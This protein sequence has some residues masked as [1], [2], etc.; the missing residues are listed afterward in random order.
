MSDERPRDRLRADTAERILRAA[1]ERLREHPQAP[2]SHEIVAEQAGVSA[3]TVY[4]HFPTQADLVRGVWQQLR[5]R[6]GTT[7]PRTLEAIV[8][9]LRALFA[10]FERNGALTRAMLAAAPRA[11]YARAGS[12]EG[13]AAF[14][15]A[16]APLLAGRPP[17]AQRQLVAQCL[18]IYSAPF[19][20]LLRERGPLCAGAAAD[21]A[22]AAMQAVLDAA[23]AS[24]PS[25]TPPPR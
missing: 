5:D 10:Q 21:A 15:E 22:V 6:T 12:A 23:R 11:N 24:V 1:F 19:W 25:P 14:R 7:W 8:P 9:E 18:A 4:R 13:R 2:F 16:L 20:Q 3:R 17:A